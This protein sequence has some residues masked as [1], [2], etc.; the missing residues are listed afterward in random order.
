MFY[1]LQLHKSKTNHNKNNNREE[2]KI[3]V[4]Y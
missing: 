1:N 4:P 3:P 2:R